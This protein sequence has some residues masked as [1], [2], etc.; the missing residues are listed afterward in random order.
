MRSLVRLGDDQILEEEAHWRPDL[1][2]LATQGHMDFLDALRGSN[3]GARPARREL[4]H[5]RSS[6]PNLSRNADP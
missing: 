2:V 6:G 4:P 1:M 5:S 3:D